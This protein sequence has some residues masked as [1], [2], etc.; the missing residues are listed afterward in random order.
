MSSK[1]QIVVTGSE[2]IINSSYNADFVEA[3]KAAIPHT[4]RDWDPI[5]EIWT[6]DHKYLERVK[7]L[8][9]THYGSVWL[10]GLG[11]IRNLKTG[12]RIETMFGG[13]GT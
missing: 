3:L 4:E 7:Q 5:E 1:C 11:A 2:V 9:T 12:E 6:T 10:E 13:A 8:A